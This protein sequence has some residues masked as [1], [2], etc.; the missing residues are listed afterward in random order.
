MNTSITL[1]FESKSIERA[2][3][4]LQRLSSS[5]ESTEE[6]LARVLVAFEKFAK[7]QERMAVGQDALQV[8]VIT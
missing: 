2:V 1:Q 6:T 5:A 4:V 8:R 7:L 3:E